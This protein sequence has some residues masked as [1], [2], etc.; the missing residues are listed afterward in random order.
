ISRYGSGKTALF[1]VQGNSFIDTLNGPDVTNSLTYEVRIGTSRF[2]GTFQPVEPPGCRTAA[3]GSAGGGMNGD[4]AGPI[5]PDSGT[6]AGPVGPASDAFPGSFGPGSATFGG[7]LGPG[8]GSGGGQGNGSPDCDWVPT[9]PGASPFVIFQ[10]LGR[11]A[12]LALSPLWFSWRD[13]VNRL[14]YLVDIGPAVLSQPPNYQG[15]IVAI[16]T[17]Q[18]L[19]YATRPSWPTLLNTPPL[20]TLVA[21][22]IA[23]QEWPALQSGWIYGW[24]VRP[25]VATP[26]GRSVSVGAAARFPHFFRVP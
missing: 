1:T 3:G 22:T 4:F 13:T 9:G 8:S 14:G 18:S 15:Q 26:D 7:P 20:S 10:R 2:Q 23:P 21:L 24:R 19:A 6:I 5:D 11:Q 17:E 16:T 12:P 25:L